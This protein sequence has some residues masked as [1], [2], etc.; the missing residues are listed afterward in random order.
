MIRNDYEIISQG[1]SG[2]LRYS[3]WAD[4][5]DIHKLKITGLLPLT[6]EGEIDPNEVN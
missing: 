2:V 1:K 5:A 6:D 3:E 4:W